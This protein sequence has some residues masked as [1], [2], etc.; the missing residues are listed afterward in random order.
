MQ[1]LE[2]LSHAYLLF[3]T[4][5]VTAVTDASETASI[6]GPMNKPRRSRFSVSRIAGSSGDA[7]LKKKIKGLL[8]KTV[9]TEVQRNVTFVHFHKVTGRINKAT[10]LSESVVVSNHL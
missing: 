8:F 3:E 10:L 5:V 6:S 1:M 2:E 4:L 9:T 7:T